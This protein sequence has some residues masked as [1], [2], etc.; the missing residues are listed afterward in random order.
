M[1]ICA[2]LSMVQLNQ[3]HSLGS[4]SSRAFHSCQPL[5][6]YLSLSLLFFH[7]FPSACVHSTGQIARRL[8]VTRP[9]SCCLERASPNRPYRNKQTTELGRPIG[10]TNCT[11]EVSI[12]S[13]GLHANRCDNCTYLEVSLIHT[14]ARPGRSALLVAI[15]VRA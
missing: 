7:F 5:P 3:A 2:Q 6:I 13:K 14:S 15:G 4:T 8:M 1:L 10:R 12:I 9:K 11:R